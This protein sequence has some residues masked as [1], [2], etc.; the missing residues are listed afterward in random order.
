MH[1]LTRWLVAIVFVVI[2]GIIF[3][4]AGLAI[5]GIV[6]GFLIN[7]G[8]RGFLIGGSLAAF[9]WLFTAVIKVAS[10]QSSQLL[11][12]AGSLVNLSGAK[13]WLLVAGSVLI[14]FVAGGL[15]GWLGGN[16]QRLN[17]SQS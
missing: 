11:T 15:G 16:L 12:L 1:N 3:G 7:S 6:A 10:G 13:A 2:G 17:S 4:L 14:A 8:R 9:F 5:G